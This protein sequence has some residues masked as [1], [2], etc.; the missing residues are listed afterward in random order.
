LENHEGR[1]RLGDLAVC[2]SIIL[3]VCLNMMECMDK[4]SGGYL[5]NLTIL[6]KCGQ[7]RE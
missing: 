7:I 2:E 6:K 1:D 3:K 5:N 4:D